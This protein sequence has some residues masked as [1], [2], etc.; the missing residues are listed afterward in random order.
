MQ[1]TLVALTAYLVLAAATGSAV[2][3]Q[4]EIEVNVRGNVDE[5]QEQIEDVVILKGVELVY[6]NWAGWWPWA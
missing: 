3:A 5:A 2:K 6:S 1:K 4:N